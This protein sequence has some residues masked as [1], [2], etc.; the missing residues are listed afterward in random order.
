[1]TKNEDHHI[2]TV[3]ERLKRY[4]MLQ[5]RCSSE[6]IRKMVDWNILEVSQ[7]RILQELINEKY[8]DEKR[9]ATAFCR[10]KFHIN[11]WGKI[12]IRKELEKKKI[13]E[14]HITVALS[15]INEDRYR[16]ELD[17]QYE[18]KE[19]TTKEKNNFVKK[20]K[21]ANYLI[22]KGYESNLIWER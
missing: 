3:I 14:K 9:Y 10:G 22:R 16:K 17:I 21:I 5:E 4:C 13:N 1:M 19:R 2:N 15:K 12:K 8:V 20:G 7:D 11:K 18:K 6:V